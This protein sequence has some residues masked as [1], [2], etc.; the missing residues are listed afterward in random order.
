MQN[1][2]FRKK[3][4]ERISSPEEMHDYM[5]VT[6][7]RLW[8]ILTAIVVL[9]GGFIA[10][11]ATTTM[12]STMPLKIMVEVFESENEETGQPEKTI[13][14]Y[15]EVP[16]TQK[17]TVTTGKVVR[18]GENIT[19]KISYIGTSKDVDTMSVF[20]EFDQENPPLKDGD[21]DAV[22]VLDAKTPISF[23]WND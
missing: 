15:A 12:E 10:Y 18:I 21:Y 19:G 14:A 8:M 7:P 3:S 9:L 5:R 11:A 1:Q 6:S 13:M 16:N 23:L 22:L 4:L 2:L 20:I 17:D